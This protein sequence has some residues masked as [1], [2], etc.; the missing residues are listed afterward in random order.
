MSKTNTQTWEQKISKQLEAKWEIKIGI[1]TLRQAE[2]N[3]WDF[4]LTGDEN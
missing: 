2:E 1:G 4:Y 3:N